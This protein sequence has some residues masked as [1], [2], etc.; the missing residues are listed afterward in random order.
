MQVWLFMLSSLVHVQCIFGQLEDTRR[1]DRDFEL[2]ERPAKS[3]IRKPRSTESEK[4]S[5]GPLLN[6]LSFADDIDNKADSNG[7]FTSA[8]LWKKN[9]PESFTICVA[10]MVEAWTT[11]TVGPSVRVFDMLKDDKLCVKWGCRPCNFWSS[12][13]GELRL[14]LVSKHMEHTRPDCKYLQIT[15]FITLFNRQHEFT[16]ALGLYT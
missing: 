11:V 6:V 12:K 5:E 14:H 1:L 7:E 4:T 3:V 2:E 15:L 8:S 16:F 10:F 9:L 13:K